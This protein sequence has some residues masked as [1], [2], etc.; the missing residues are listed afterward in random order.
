MT[1]ECPFSTLPPAPPDHCLPRL[2]ERLCTV[3]LEVVPHCPAAKAPLEGD[4]THT[5]MEGA[6]LFRRHT[7]RAQYTAAAPGRRITPN[8]RTKTHSFMAG[9]YTLRRRHCT[10][11]MLPL[12]LCCVFTLLDVDKI[13]QCIQETTFYQIYNFS[14]YEYFHGFLSN[15][16]LVF[17]RTFNGLTYVQDVPG[18]SAVILFQVS[19][20]PV[21]RQHD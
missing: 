14:F 10:A 15:F 17:R 12:F 7:Y 1:T 2:A 11:P 20:Q 8:V 5:S 9:R 6:T 13:F 4:N 18:L 21:C 16:L 3:F 19:K